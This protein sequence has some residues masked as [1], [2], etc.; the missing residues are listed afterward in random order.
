M[1]RLANKRI[2][3]G[4][5]GSIAAYKSADL[6]RRLREQGAEVQ[7]V[8]TRAGAEFI[9]P[10][11]LQA[12][13][14]RAV[15]TQFL[16]AEAEA[17][18]GHIALARWADLILVAPASADL[19]ARL[20]Q[21]R[22]DDLLGALCLATAAPLAIAPAM[23][24]QMWAHPATRAN[25][26]TLRE[27]G[28][29]VFG[30]AAGDQACGENGPG[31][32]VEPADLVSKTAALFERGCLQGCRVMVTAGPTQE[33][34]DP[35][36]FIANRSSGRMGY[37]LANAAEE[38]GA[39]VR[40][41]SGPVE[42]PLHEGVERIET[43]T[44]QQMH[45]TVAQYINECDIFIAAAA[46]SDYRP[47]HEAGRKIKRDQHS[48]ALELEPTPDILA[49]VAALPQRPFVVGFAAETEEL[50]RNAHAKLEGKA[51]DMIAANLVGLPGR[52]F[53][54]DENAV[55]VLWRGG[56]RELGL[57][58]KDKLARTLIT[59]IAER[60]HAEGAVESTGSKARG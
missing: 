10:L 28:V 48:M 2:V 26:S 15:R 40:L 60:Y 52:G 54:S 42:R 22:A 49:S 51:L 3:L 47:R 37:A 4:V 8:L 50:E 19:I 17:A 27:R 55:T 24:R 59:I 9:T 35:V 13:S 25:V 7:V 32:M 56:G 20:A 45:D 29:H 11:T 1:K 41:I 38:A 31:R 30:P 57:T 43:Q 44:A 58:S 21:G 6:V 14:G 18:M 16:D 53:D 12:L 23:N 46:V 5:T 36:R 33:A 34:I 39:Q